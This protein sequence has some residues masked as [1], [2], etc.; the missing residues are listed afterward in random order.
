[1]ELVNKMMLLILLLCLTN[2]TEAAEKSMNKRV[3]DMKLLF[4]ICSF[5]I[6]YFSFH[7][8]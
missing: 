7:L 6:R 1:M 8:F 2:K 5:K 3:C 4:R